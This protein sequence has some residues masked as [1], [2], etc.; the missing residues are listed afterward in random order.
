MQ[1]KEMRI[2]KDGAEYMR[3]PKNAAYR[4]AKKGNT[5]LVYMNHDDIQIASPIEF[6]LVGTTKEDFNDEVKT[7]TKNIRSWERGLDCLY[8]VKIGG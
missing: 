3:V 2:I 4:H 5:L 6:T 1:F 8:F 7:A